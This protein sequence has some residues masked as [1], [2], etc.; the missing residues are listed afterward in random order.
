MAPTA[1]YPCHRS[2]ATTI[3]TTK[4]ARALVRRTHRQGL[5]AGRPRRG[6]ADR[7]R[8]ARRRDALRDADASRSPCPAASARSTRQARS[9]GERG[10]RRPRPAE[11]ETMM[12]RTGFRR[13]APVAAAP[14]APAVARRC[15]AASLGRCPNCG[16]GKL[17]ASFLKTVDQ[18]RALR[19]GDPPPPRRRPAGLSRRGHRRPHRRRR[20]HGVE[21]TSTL[22]TWQHLAIWVPL[23]HRRWRWLCCGRSRAPSSACNGRSTCTAS[24]ARTTRIETHPEL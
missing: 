14:R 5:S 15:C 7:G 13:R 10:P 20:L 8:A 17:F 22:S 2:A 1:S 4:T 21:A 9:D 6:E 19:R 18:L 24:A 23:T 3:S 11:Q 16:E 12:E